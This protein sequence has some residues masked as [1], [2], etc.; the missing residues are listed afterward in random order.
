MPTPTSEQLAG[1]FYQIIP[2]LHDYLMKPFES[3]LR[4]ELSPMQFYTLTALKKYR[5]MTMTGLAAH[6]GVSK[7]QMTKIV[8]RLV[9]LD[10]VQREFDEADRRIIRICM[11]PGADDFIDRC[12]D[13][14]CL[15]VQQR[16]GALEEEDALQLLQ[17]MDIIQQV[18]PKLA[19][20]AENGSCACCRASR[21]AE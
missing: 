12:R 17:A 3:V 4:E 21:A 5:C 8:G 16:L 10:L 11:A 9:E 20:P 19:A 15:R 14:L 18:L 6:F 7:Q 2:L 13:E 1:R